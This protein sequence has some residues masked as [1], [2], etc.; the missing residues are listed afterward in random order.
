[1]E[2]PVTINSSTNPYFKLINNPVKFRLFLLQKLP[3]AYF[4]GLRVEEVNEES[5]TIS[6]PF[7]WFTKNPFRSA[8][9]ACL[10]MAA[11]MST[12]ILA[13]ASIYKTKPPVSMLITG[14]EGKFYKKATGKTKFVCKDGATIKKAIQLAISD[15]QSQ[16]VTAT[17]TGYNTHNEMVAEFIFTWSF[18]TKVVS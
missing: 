1:M 10:S 9:F 11:E 17:S 7:K 2:A 8:Y 5:A 13:M 6:V 4:A 3:A 12:G 16:T 14:M 18:K 15:A